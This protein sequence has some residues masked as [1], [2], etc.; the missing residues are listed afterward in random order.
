[1]T[2]E[3]VIIGSTTSPTNSDPGGKVLAYYRGDLSSGDQLL[4]Y[5]NSVTNYWTQNN[6]HSDTSGAP[7]LTTVYEVLYNSLSYTALNV[8]VYSVQGGGGQATGNSFDTTVF[9]L[10]SR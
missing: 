5:M 2:D 10:G 8:E 7:Y 1:M 3:G 6:E 4:T 9:W